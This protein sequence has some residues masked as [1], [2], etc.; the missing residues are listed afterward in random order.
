MLARLRNAASA[1]CGG[2][3]MPMELQ[4]AADYRTCVRETLDD[5]VTRVGAPL[6]ADLYHAGGSAALVASGD[7]R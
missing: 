7:A 1:V 6:V 3:P 4:K 2:E 5:A